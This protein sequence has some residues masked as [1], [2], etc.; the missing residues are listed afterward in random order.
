MKQIA[1][2]KVILP[3]TEVLRREVIVFDDN[4]HPVH[5]FPLTNEIPFTEWHNKT[6]VWPITEHNEG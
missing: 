1:F 2:S 3:S 6:F 4:G 5:H